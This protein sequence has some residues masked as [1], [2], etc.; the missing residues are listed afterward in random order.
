MAFRNATIQP[1]EYTPKFLDVL[2]SKRVL[3]YIILLRYSHYCVYHIDVLIIIFADVTGLE[4]KISDIYL[5]TYLPNYLPI[6]SY[7][8]ILDILSALYYSDHNIKI[9]RCYFY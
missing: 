5:S 9:V 3:L 4:I 6:S 8:I 2:L 7:V 1:L